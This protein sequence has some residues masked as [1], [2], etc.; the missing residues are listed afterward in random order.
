MVDHL[1][2]RGATLISLGFPREGETDRE[3]VDEWVPPGSGT[4]GNPRETRG[5]PEG[6]TR[7]RPEGDPRETRGNRQG[8]GRNRQAPAVARIR[9]T[10]TEWW[11]QCAAERREAEVRCTSP[12]HCGLSCL[13]VVQDDV[14]L[15]IALLDLG[16]ER[17]S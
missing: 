10:E 12:R 15:D 9:V 2:Q 14:V 3:T 13:R 16:T 1:L 6:G 4:G 5:R 8:N 7:G 17:L 11:A